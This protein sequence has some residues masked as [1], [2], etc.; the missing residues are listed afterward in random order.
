M[1]RKSV[2]NKANDKL[3]EMAAQGEP[4]SLLRGGRARPGESWICENW[5]ACV[6]FVAYSRRGKS[7]SAARVHGQPSVPL[8]ST[9][10]RILRGPRR[11][12]LED[13]SRKQIAY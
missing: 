1:I 7:F 12:T 6:L 3:G 10:S 5:G 11:W 13:R 2:Q 4:G 8:G 9:P